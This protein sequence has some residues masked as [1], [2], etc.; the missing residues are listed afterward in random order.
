M[1]N[2]RAASSPVLHPKDKLVKSVDVL[3]AGLVC[4]GEHDEEA[5]SSSHILLTHGTELLLACCVQY[6]WKKKEIK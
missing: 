4:D 5:I 3:E 1:G 6:C 2:E